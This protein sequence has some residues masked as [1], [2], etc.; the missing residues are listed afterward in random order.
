MFV[1]V[2]PRFSQHFVSADFGFRGR[3][4][5]GL[6]LV[7]SG[8]IARGPDEKLALDVVPR[9]VT[10]IEVGRK[11]FCKQQTGDSTYCSSGPLPR[12]EKG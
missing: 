4:S 2:H 8:Q 10:H 6:M 12:A 9:A 7:I 3:G 5:M 11:I 1:C